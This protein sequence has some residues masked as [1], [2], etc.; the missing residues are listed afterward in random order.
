M[1]SEKP[2][3]LTKLYNSFRRRPVFIS[4]IRRLHLLILK[5]NISYLIKEGFDKVYLLDIWR[6]TER[7]IGES[8][9][10]ED[11]LSK[12]VFGV[13]DPLIILS[14]AENLSRYR[15][16]LAQARSL[17]TDTGGATIRSYGFYPVITIHSGLRPGT[18]IMKCSDGEV[19]IFRL[20][21]HNKIHDLEVSKKYSEALKILSEAFEIYGL[22]KQSDA[23]K[24]LMRELGLDRVEAQKIIKDLYEQ[25]LI[26]LDKGGYIVINHLS[27]DVHSH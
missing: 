14:P 11:Y 10:F 3:V 25:G 13:G 21:E 15:N 24:I 26:R 23:V 22:Y 6:I 5:H 27:L 2:R 20:D 9:L 1:D 16:E 12:I 19:L 4:K 17:Y 7:V 8:D 18:Y